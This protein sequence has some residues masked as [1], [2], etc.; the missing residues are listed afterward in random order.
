MEFD[1]PFKMLELRDCSEL[2]A[3]IAAAPQSE[4]ETNRLRQQ[5]FD[6]H[7]QTQSLVML[8]ISCNPWPQA[9][10]Y[11]ED[12]WGRLAS[13]ALP[14]MREVIEQH[15]EPGGIVLRA[16][17]AKLVPGGIIKPHVDAHPSFRHAH[18][19]HIP[20]TS[21]AKVRFNIGGRP[22]RFEV[23]KVYELNN[24]LQHSVMNRGSEDRI[25]FIFD[26][27]P[28]TKRGQIAASGVTSLW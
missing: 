27:L 6:V 11:R 23:G 10:I 18:R 2:H 1:A 17:A 15:Y 12:G 19:I 25:T 9:E 4:W 28:P 14:L 8:F 16:M 13:A 20:I 26:Y 3:C 22:Y 21:N 24:Q 5:T 7:Y